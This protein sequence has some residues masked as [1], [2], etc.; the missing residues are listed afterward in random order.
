MIKSSQY[1]SKIWIERR[2]RIKDDV[3]KSYAELKTFKEVAKKFKVGAKVIARIIKENG[4]EFKSRGE[5]GQL[6]DICPFER[7]TKEEKSYW[8]GYIAGDGNISPN[9]NLITLVT[10]DLEIVNHY[11]CFIGEG[12]KNTWK[13][14]GCSNIYSLTFSHHKT[15]EYLINKGITPQKSRTLIFKF[16]INWDVIRGLFDADGSFSQ[17]RL[18]ITSGSPRLIKQLTKFFKKYDIDVKI[19]DKGTGICWDVFLL[20][21]KETIN[22]VYNY[23][24]SQNPKYLLTRKKEQIRRYIE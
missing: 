13:Y 10:A 12:L 23:F 14:N 17:N 16:K 20:G 18:K 15:K 9:K 4:I 6:V 3:I 24:Y 1:E 19:Q 8:I 5:V 7:S 21:G 22:K 2:E 11:K